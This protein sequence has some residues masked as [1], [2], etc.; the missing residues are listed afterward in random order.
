MRSSINP[1]LLLVSETYL[2]YV[3][4]ISNSL[5]CKQGGTSLSFNILPPSPRMVSFDW[6][7]FVDHFLP[8]YEP[9]WILLSILFLLMHIYGYFLASP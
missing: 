8:S 5:P 4:N 1:T 3:Y 2:K 7:D 6:N 9:L